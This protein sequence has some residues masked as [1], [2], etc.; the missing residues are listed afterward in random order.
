MNTFI[1]MVITLGVLALGVVIF[2]IVA[3]FV[4]RLMFWWFDTVEEWL[5]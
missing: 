5:D 1:A 2:I 4:A 3:P